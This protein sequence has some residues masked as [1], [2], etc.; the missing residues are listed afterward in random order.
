MSTI[1]SHS[2]LNISEKVEIEAWLQR[3]TY[4]NGLGELNGHV[5]D[6]VTWPGKLKLVTQYA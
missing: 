6:D 4:G 3:T 5:T 2:P 1:A